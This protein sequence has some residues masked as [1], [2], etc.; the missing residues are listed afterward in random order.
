MRQK[1]CPCKILC[2]GVSSNCLI[3]QLEGGT[4][5]KDP[6]DLTGS[7]ESLC[8]DQIAAASNTTKERLKLS[9]SG[10][11]SAN[12]RHNPWATS[13]PKCTVNGIMEVRF[14]IVKHFLTPVNSQTRILVKTGHYTAN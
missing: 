6:L 11:F 8:K 10:V 14:L 9:W 5:Q 1:P 4:A 2:P 3:C 13:R 7:E 12:F